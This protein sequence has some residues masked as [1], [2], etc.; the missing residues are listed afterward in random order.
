MLN[1]KLFLLLTAAALCLSLPSGAQN[2][3]A[4][5]Y[6]AL[7]WPLF[8]L[9][10]STETQPAKLDISFH[11]ALDSINRHRTTVYTHRLE[12]Y[13]D[14]DSSWVR[15]NSIT[16]E[17]LAQCQKEFD[18]AHNVAE[19]NW[20]YALQN[21]LP[22]ENFL[23]SCRV[24][25][26]RGVDFPEM[27]EEPLQPAWIAGEKAFFGALSGVYIGSMGNL[28]DISTRTLGVS[29]EAGLLRGK[30][31]FSAE[32]VGG[33]GDY[34]PYKLSVS[35]KISSSYNKELTGTYAVEDKSSLPYFGVFVK[36]SRAIV[37]TRD[38]RLSLFGGMGYVSRGEVVTKKRMDMSGIGFSEGIAWDWKIS[39]V[40]QACESPYRQSDYV[41][42]V[43]LYSNQVSYPYPDPY[44]F[45]PS[46]NLSVG[47]GYSR[48]Q[49]KPVF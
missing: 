26:D 31:L 23:D 39:S 9:K 36:Y 29:L 35:G 8:H 16:D 10:D 46:L 44:S 28:K 1:K 7:D 2:R 40:I 18:R 22:P 47:I 5:K 34:V 4:W 32:L 20:R 12:A 13:M 48:H 19:K 17:V 42:R 15:T 14:Y 37:E 33:V 45:S 24:Q 27:Q 41:L 11:A 43:R 25:F 38:F 49:P 30:N 6:G 21:N 3:W